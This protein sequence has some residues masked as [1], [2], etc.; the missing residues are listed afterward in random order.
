[1]FVEFQRKKQIDSISV[2]LANITQKSSNQ[3]TMLFIIRDMQGG[4]K[5]ACSSLFYSNKIN[6]FCRKCDVQKDSGN[7]YI[8]CNNIKMKDI[9]EMVEQNDTEQLKALNQYK[10]QNAWFNVEFGGRPYR[11]ISTAC[12][13]ELLHALENGL[14]SECIKVLFVRIKSNDY[15]AELDRLVEKLTTLP[16]QN[17]ISYGADKDMPRLLWKDGITNMTDVTALQKLVLC[18]QLW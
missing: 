4:D 12:L 17:K 16:R 9:Q 15:L 6:R 14:I 1:M 11:I 8:K 13:I 5:M 18:L 10:V 7:P 2:I 3:G